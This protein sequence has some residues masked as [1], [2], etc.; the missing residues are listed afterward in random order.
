MVVTGPSGSK[1]G[2]PPA[3]LIAQSQRSARCGRSALLA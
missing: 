3:G 2:K 1:R